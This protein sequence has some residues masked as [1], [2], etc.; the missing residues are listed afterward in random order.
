MLRLHDHTRRWI[1]RALF[2]LFGALPASMVVGWCIYMNS[3]AAVSAVR[4][5]L[6]A[7]LGLKVQLAQVSFPRPGCTR[8]TD[9][10]LTDP[11]SGETVASMRQVEIQTTSLGKTIIASQPE[12][13]VAA[14]AHWGTLIDRWLHRETDAPPFTLRL[15]AGELTL[16]WPEGAQTFPHCSIQFATSASGNC[17]QV[18]QQASGDFANAVSP[19]LQWERTGKSGSMATH[20]TLCAQNTLLPAPMLAALLQRE[21]RCGPR[22]TFRGTVDVLETPDGWQ[23]ELTG[24]LENIDLHSLVSEQFPHQLGGTADLTIGHA[25]LHAGRLEEAAGSLHA[26]PGSISPSLLSA[27]ANCLGLQRRGLENA[28]SAT[29]GNVI[30]YEEL[31]TEFNL[32]ALGLMLHGKCEKQPGVLLRSG[33]Q[34]LLTETNRGAIPVVAL[35]KMLV[36]DSRLQVPATRQTDW[37]LPWLPVPDVIPG[38]PNAAPQA[39]LRG[40]K[41]LH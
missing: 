14:V 41:D 4:A 20:V 38:D 3:P 31:S 15:S 29:A 32:T 19:V 24:H 16:R 10:Q 25:V 18:W 21:N 23:A 37:L 22:A 26:G 17:I 13:N 7:A 5:E 35:V 34:A 40:V 28:N 9:L 2:L 36:P 30:A 33:E 6:Q 8:I 12:M 27:A 11:E 1:C 39:R